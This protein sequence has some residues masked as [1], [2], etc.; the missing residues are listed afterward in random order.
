MGKRTDLHAV[1][2]AIVGNVYFQ[3]PE[4]TQMKY[5]CILYSRQLGDTKFA[6]DTPYVH[7]VQYQVMVIGTDPDSEI[8]GK[9]AMLPKCLFVR[10]Y[11]VS[12][13]HHDVYNL[14]Y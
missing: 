3:P 1:F 4:T 5:P 8:L 12:N 7:D 9:V 14:Y 10:H 13:L 6:N 11:V 2:K